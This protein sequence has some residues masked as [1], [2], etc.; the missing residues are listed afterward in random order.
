VTT[1]DTSELER[2]L[3]DVEPVVRSIVSR[4][5]RVQFSRSDLA[6]TQ[7]ALDLVSFVVGDVTAR[8][9]A[10]RVRAESLRDY[11]AVVAYHACAEHLRGTRAPRHRLQLKIR[12]FLT[13]RPRYAV[14]T[15]A[16]G[17]HACGL[18][19]WK[20]TGRM[21]DGARVNAIRA[22]A[23]AA[24]PRLSGLKNAEHMKPA[25]W[26]APLGALFEFL[27]GAALLNDVFAAVASVA[28]PPELDAPEE[29]ERAANTPS[30]E[31][32][33]RANEIYRIV[34]DGILQ[35]RLHWRRAF[36]LNPPRGFEVDQLPLRGLVTIGQLGDALQLT[37]TETDTLLAG[38]A[39]GRGG[40][41]A[42]AGLTPAERFARVWPHLPLKDAVIAQLFAEDPQYVVNLRRLAKD[43]IRAYVQTRLSP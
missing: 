17:E 43:E 23:A 19:D 4:K 40:V 31:D 21:A 8:Y 14:W 24:I 2:L 39:S 5:L 3:R 35:L 15:L 42:T 6:E 22:N 18:A 26:E 30:P 13:H 11:A 10:G 33:A 27:D 28:L 9:R 16:T 38:A 29:V 20:T 36:L 12:Y 1:G 37:E 34:W 41:S 32:E 25:D 7:D